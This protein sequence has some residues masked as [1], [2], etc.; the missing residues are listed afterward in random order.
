MVGASI[1]ATICAAGGRGFCCLSEEA[2]TSNECRYAKYRLPYR[3]EKAAPRRLSCQ[4]LAYPFDDF[5]H[6]LIPYPFRNIST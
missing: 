4:P 6:G 3:R 1:G 2:L 5:I